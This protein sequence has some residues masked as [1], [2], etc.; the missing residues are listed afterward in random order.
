MFV[1][2]VESKR[3]ATAQRR[4]VWTP[5]Q[6]TGSRDL[7][8]IIIMELGANLGSH[9]FWPPLFCICAAPMASYSL[10]RLPESP[11]QQE[12]ESTREEEEKEETRCWRLITSIAWWWGSTQYNNDD[13]RPVRSCTLVAYIR[14]RRSSS[15]TRLVTLGRKEKNQ[16]NVR[17]LTEHFVLFFFSKRIII[18]K[19]F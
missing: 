19:I 12:R 1:W 3:H 11:V 5:S 10:L 18:I 7:V 9:L 4:F 2:S 17:N 13:V 15:T 16:G 8:I 6:S 14:C